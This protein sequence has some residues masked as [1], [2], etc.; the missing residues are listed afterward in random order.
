MI[1][2]KTFEYCNDCATDKP[3]LAN[4]A[5]I[6]QEIRVPGKSPTTYTFLQCSKCGHLWQRIVDS[7]FGGRA[8]FYSR[9][10]KP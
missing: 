10:T 4:L 5:V 3:T 7:G 9:L 1:E 6:G 8:T 2:S